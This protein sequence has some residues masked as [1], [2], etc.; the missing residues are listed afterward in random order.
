MPEVSVIVPVYNAEAALQRCIDSILNQEFKD[1][2]LL[3]MDDG[4]KDSSPAICDAAAEKDPRVRVIHK[5]NSGVSDTRNLGL[6]LAQGTFVQFLDADDW[7][8]EDSTKMLV[9]T[10]T[11]KDAD[12]VV[13]EFYRVVGDHLSRKGSIE[14]DM[15]LTRQAYA[16]FM[17]YSPADY[18]Y[19]VLWNKLYRRSILEKHHIRM[20]KAISFCEDFIFNLEYVLH[21]NRIA[22]LLVPVYYYV[23]TDGSLVAQN[24]NLSKLIAM[25]TSV[26]QYYD[27][28]FRQLLDE[29]EYSKERMSIASFL[30]SP[31]TDDFTIP[32][33]PGTVK[34]GEETVPV[35]TSK[36]ESFLQESYYLNKLYESY[37]QTVAMKNELSVNA[38]RVFAVIYS[39]GTMN[40]LKEIADLS[41]LSEAQALAEGQM[42]AAKRIINISLSPLS[43]SAATD[44]GAG[45]IHDL[46]H[47]QNDL[48]AVCFEG[49]TEEEMEAAEIVF[50][51]VNANLKRRLSGEGNH[52]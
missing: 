42:L 49:M 47:V 44:R 30:V 25:K 28:F 35:Y 29:K 12:L 4:S 51:R 7:I 27:E 39:R 2:E 3:L 11:E 22:P 15:V 19:G 5:E 17:K 40:S 50:D 20:N 46:E 18:Y 24:M 33:T 34:V 6:D 26:Y 16:E 43:V 38:V 8:T 13:A 23:K 52:A 36:A 21:C 9:R 1:L 14:S 37:L 48:K 45:L 32:F 31:A 41:G 10:A